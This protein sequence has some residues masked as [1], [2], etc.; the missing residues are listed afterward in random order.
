[1]VDLPYVHGQICVLRRLGLEKQANDLVAQV[2]AA[3]GLPMP[4]A[5][6]R[7]SGLMSKLQGRSLPA[8]AGLGIGALVGAGMLGRELTQ[9]PRMEVVPSAPIQPLFP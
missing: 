3:E 5:P 8:K 1:M 6:S 9:Q 2:A 7:L 4:K